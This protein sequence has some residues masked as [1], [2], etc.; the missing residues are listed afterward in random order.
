MIVAAVVFGIGIQVPNVANLDG[1]T[2]AVL[3]RT[4][5]VM[6]G[7]ISI[8]P[9]HGMYINHSQEIVFN[10]ENLSWVVGCLP[11]TYMPAIVQSKGHST[12]VDIIGLLP[13]KEKEFSHLS[14][15]L[16]EG[17]FINSLDGRKSRENVTVLG[18]DFAKKLDVGL[19]DSVNVTM[20]GRVWRLRVVGIVNI[21]L[22]GV[23]ERAIFVHKEKIDALYNLTDSSTEILV[24][25]DDPFL[26]SGHLKELR[27]MFPN[28]EIK[29]WEEEMNY[30]KDITDTNN[31][32]KMISQVMTLV[33]VVVPVAVLMYV[34]V[35]NRRQE[36]GI[37]LATGANPGDI[38]RIFLFETVIIGVIGV[39]GGVL[40]GGGICVYY[41]FY[42]VVNRPNFVVKPLLKLSTF[43]I[44]A[45]ILFTAT[46][47]A[48]LYPAIRASRVNPVEAI[49]KE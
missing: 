25:T 17:R 30:V 1:S 49:W 37:L 32:L 44:P 20:T 9:S 28:L 12:G 39:I 34:N 10:V 45:V 5:N 18:D 47:L 8:K 21:G 13:E 31:K 14:R 3:D 48:G 23:D 6:S 26:L 15:F 35:K 2:S 19:G 27:G 42:P 43:L 24:R 7:H 4:V 40:L 33:G 36:I 11:R 16:I 38:F 29:S 46:L 22:G 41:M